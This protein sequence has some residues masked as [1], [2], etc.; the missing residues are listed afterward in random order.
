MSVLPSSRV[1]SPG[2]LASD[3]GALRGRV[4]SR[5]HEGAPEAAAPV[6]RGHLPHRGVAGAAGDVSKVKQGHTPSALV[7]AQ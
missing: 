3:P 4:A 2:L 7:L 6:H 1:A 5:G